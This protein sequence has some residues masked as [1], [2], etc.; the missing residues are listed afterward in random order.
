MS[1]VLKNRRSLTPSSAPSAGPV[2]ES[3]DDAEREVHATRRGFARHEISARVTLVSVD[4]SAHADPLEGWALNVSRG[5][6]RV[7]LEGK[8]DLG[9]EFEITM[10]E[11]TG[12]DAATTRR[13]GR[14]VWVQDEPDGVVAGIEFRPLAQLTGGPGAKA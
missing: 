6:V 1:G 8:V 14:I 3:T 12:A 5:G 13:L 10:T 2:L 7:I 9:A 11:G 4:P